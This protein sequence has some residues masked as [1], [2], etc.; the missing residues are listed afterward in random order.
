MK[1][2]EVQS[3]LLKWGES[4]CDWAN[5]DDQTMM[6]QL[7]R[8]AHEIDRMRRLKSGGVGS[9]DSHPD[10]QEELKQIIVECRKVGLF[11]VPVGELEYWAKQLMAGG[12]SKLR[13][14]EW[15][16]EAVRRIRVTK[17]YETDIFKFMRDIEQFHIGEI[18]RLATDVGQP[19]AP[20]AIP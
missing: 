3:R 15:A 6:C 2:T 12:P 18:H 7:R 10:I 1:E 9:F 8:L 17:A 19:E 20:K 5:N 14:S 4:P 13:K 11:L 16:N